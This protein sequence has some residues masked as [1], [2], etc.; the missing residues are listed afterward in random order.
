MKYLV[1]GGGGFLG[2]AIVRQLI[3]RGDE[4]RSFSRGS[5]PE[6]DELGVEQVSGTICDAEAVKDVVEGADQVI[7]VASKVG[8]W[9]RPEDFEAVNVGGTR[10][11]LAA[12]RSHGI[13]SMVHTSTP[14]VVFDGTDMEGADESLPYPDHYEAEYPRTKAIAEREVLAASDAELRTVALRPHIVWG[15]R[16]T[17]LC[18]RIVTRA[19]AGKLRRLSG[20]QK[21]VDVCYVDDAARAHLLAADK[22]RDGGEAAD[23]VAGRAFFITSGKPIETWVMIDRILDAADLPAVEKRVSP[24]MALFLGSMLERVHGLFGI[25]EEPAMT[26]WVAQ[27]LATAHWFDISAARRD[28]G[29]EPRVNLDEGMER[30]RAWLQT[31][32]L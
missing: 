6:L 32:N 20:P 19:R 26:R 18:A 17:S 16:D 2:G 7:H 31:A 9:G 24:R 4:V 11:V 22:L 15:P 25:E 3:A 5:Y 8:A 29:Y 27:E 21:K 1:T 10:N 23:R 28:L 13:R 30:L 12:C 14:S